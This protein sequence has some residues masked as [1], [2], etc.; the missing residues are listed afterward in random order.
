MTLEATG[1]PI[2]PVDPPHPQH[3]ARYSSTAKHKDDATVRAHGHVQAMPRQFNWIS[4]LG[5]GFSITNSWVAYL[6]CFGQTLAYGGAQAGI[7]AL[8]VAF[9]V[10]MTVTLGLAELASTFPSSGG[11]YHF[12]Y[13][14]SPDRTKHYSAYVVG[15]LSMLG[16]W[17]ATCSGVSLVAVCINGIAS[18]YHAEYVATQWQ[19]YLMYLGASVITGGF[20]SESSLYIK[21]S[22]ASVMP[23]FA[24]SKQI[25]RVTQCSLFLSLAGYLV[26]FVVILSR[27][28]QVQPGSFLLAPTQGNS[29]WGRGAAWLLAINSSMYAYAGPDAAIHICEELPQ[30]GRRVPQ[31]MIMTLAIG[32]VTSISLFVACMFFVDDID[33]VRDA[34]LPSLALIYQITGNRSIT[35]GLSTILAIIYT[36]SLPAQWVTSGR[37]A[38]AFARDNG[39]PFPEYFSQI[40]NNFKFPVHTTLA[41]FLF[42]SLYGLLY[43]ASTTA[44]NSIITSAVL[45]LNITYVV[46][47]G[48]LLVRGRSTLPKRYFNLGWTGYFCNG[49]AVVWIVIQGVLT[50]LPP[51]P[52]VTLGSMN[53]VGPKEVYWAED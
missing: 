11:Q 36:T 35:L 43:L 9:V 14:L 15:W 19:T 21:Y 6:S 44:F 37:I 25:S 45:F 2:I 23:V 51:S 42:M 31:V 46:P 12:C 3:G 10:Q 48:I 4:A 50:C 20:Y 29:G 13:L 16:W 1:K 22:L 39:V 34:P 24:A 32:A 27:H 30:P 26:F 17:V 40:N 28:Q 7:I 18:F 38:W 33:A 53:Y 8:V 41:A 52:E 49:F 47:Q 5:L